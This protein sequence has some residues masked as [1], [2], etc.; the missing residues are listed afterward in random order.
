M[1]YTI[2]NRYTACVLTIEGRFL[3]SIERRAWQQ[4]IDDLKAAGQTRLV[5]D[6]AKT[7]FMD[8][9]GVGLIAWAAEV[10]REAGGVVR[11]AGMQTRVKNL[12]VTTRLLG[13]MF[14]DYSSVEAALDSFAKSPGLAY[15]ISA[16]IAFFW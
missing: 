2:E 5:I 9:T 11:L 4:T 13:R 7:D 8:S 6:L 16:E 3:G 1:P 15:C 14:E 12:F 10:L